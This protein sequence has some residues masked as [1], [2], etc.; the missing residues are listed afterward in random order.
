MGLGS[1]ILTVCF[2]LVSAGVLHQLCLFLALFLF[3][4]TLERFIEVFY[5]GRVHDQ[6]MPILLMSTI[7]SIFLGIVL[8]INPFHQLLIS[9]VLGIFMILI[10]ILNLAS[11]S[12]LSN[13]I[14][15]FISAME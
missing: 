9:E 10:S 15:E 14:S 4:T 6:A 12:L 5:L 11:I 3:I 8:I 13:R 1:L 2:F 7:L